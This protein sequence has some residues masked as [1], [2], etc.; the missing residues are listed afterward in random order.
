MK[1]SRIEQVDEE[2]LKAGGKENISSRKV[3]HSSVP[4]D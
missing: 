2:V 4:W 3:N 1:Q